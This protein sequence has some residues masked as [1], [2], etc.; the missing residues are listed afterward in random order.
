MSGEPKFFEI[1]DRALLQKIFDSAQKAQLPVTV[2]L[3]TQSLRFESTFAEFT[4]NTKRISLTRP[5]EVP[6]AL[7]LDAI[8]KQQSDDVLGS[9][10]LQATNFFFK[11]RY[12]AMPRE[13]WIQLEAPTMIYKLQ[14]RSTLRIPFRRA[15]APKMTL[16][17]PDKEFSPNKPIRPEDLLTV[18]VLDVSAGGVAIAVPIEHKGAFKRGARVVD[19][20]FKVKG[21]EIA[22]NGKITHV[23]ET[24]NDQ[25]KPMLKIGIQ[26][27]G[28]K[29]HHEKHL[30]KF[31]LEESRRLFTG[32][33]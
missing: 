16:F 13:D 19:M 17:S 1:K 24:T 33:I 4:P 7:F 20:R 21:L 23:A 5:Q 2:W 22:T 27:A 30:V 29:V 3:K 9:F 14:R 11:T 32:L 31:A 10:Q 25:G 26:F 15:D 28:L 12:L 18:R 6:V 8:K